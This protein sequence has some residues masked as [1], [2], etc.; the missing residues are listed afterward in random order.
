M[1][2]CDHRLRLGVGQ[3]DITPPLGTALYGYQPDILATSVHDR[4]TATAYVLASGTQRAVL[5]SA[6]VCEIAEKECDAIRAAIEKETGI[7][8]N[9]VILTATH[10]HSGPNLIG[11]F[12]WGEIDRDYL[13]GIFVPGILSAVKTAAESLT[14]VRM[15]YAVGESRVGISRREKTAENTVAL[16]QNPWGTYDPDMLVMSFR[17]DRDRTVANL[18]S[19]TCHGTSAGM[20]HEI[21]RDWSGIMTDRLQTLTGGVSAFF[22]GAEGDVGPRLSNGQTVGDISYTEELGGIA[23]GDALRVYRSIRAYEESSLAVGDGE[24][25]IPLDGRMPEAQARALYENFRGNTVNAA[26]Q[27]AHHLEEVL[28]SYEDKSF[29]EQPFLSFRQ[30]VLRIGGV[31]FVSFPYEIVSEIGLRIRAYAKEEYVVS[32]S[33]AN[34]ARGYFVTEDMLPVGGYEVEMFRTANIQPYGK[35]ADFALITETLKNLKNNK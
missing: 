11:N 5:I 10:T 7:D 14:H 2:D 34:G 24:V 8:R 9:N 23:A 32:L 17:D 25:R 22:N 18:V 20:N 26:G 3:S 13:D 27:T 19:Y 35:N 30:T 28:A 1:N 6:T 31:A 29:R 12:G 21:T 4:L 15:G 16:G 33:N